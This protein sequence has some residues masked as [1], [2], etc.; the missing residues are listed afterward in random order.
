MWPPK[1][2]RVSEELQ[3]PQIGLSLM[4]AT[5]HPKRV[6][7]TAAH[8]PATPPPTTTKSYFTLLIFRGLCFRRNS[9]SASP[10]TGGT[11]ALSVVRYMAS[12]RPSK[13]VI[14]CKRNSA[15]PFAMSTAP[16]Y[17][18]IHSLPV[19]PNSSSSRVPSMPKRNAPAPR[20]SLQGDVQ[21]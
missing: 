16:A 20:F 10:P 9:V 7:A 6:A 1:C 4:S 3:P 2:T 19:E 5:S 12:Q 14:S 11:S 21:L 18:H 13:P 15:S 8:I 17:C